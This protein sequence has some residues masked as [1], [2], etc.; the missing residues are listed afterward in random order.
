MGHSSRVAEQRRAILDETGRLKQERRKTLWEADYD[1]AKRSMQLK[2]GSEIPKA[3]DGFRDG[4]QS[5][6]KSGE[7]NRQDAK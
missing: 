2:T 5:K 1:Y 3:H 7:L 4:G 6:K